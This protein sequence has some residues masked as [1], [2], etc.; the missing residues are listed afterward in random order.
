MLEMQ[1]A[2]DLGICASASYPVASTGWVV[3]G[4]ILTLVS[5]KKI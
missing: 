1:K 3:L 2:L 5:K 4:G